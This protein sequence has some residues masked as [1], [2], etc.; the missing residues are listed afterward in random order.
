M[1]KHPLIYKYPNN[2]HL[3][4]TFHILVKYLSF[5]D[6]LTYRIQEVLFFYTITFFELNIS[7][8]GAFLVIFFGIRGSLLI[9]YTHLSIFFSS[10][11]IIVNLLYHIQITSPVISY[12]CVSVPH[13]FK[14]H[15]FS[16]HHWSLILFFALLLL[17]HFNLQ[18]KSLYNFFL[19]YNFLKFKTQNISSEKNINH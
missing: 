13:F 17:V 6:I 16:M 18:K 14:F 12:Y 2:N 3:K 10:L 15:K 5:N 11:Q 7:P 1:K 8:G 19:Y 4:C 9:K